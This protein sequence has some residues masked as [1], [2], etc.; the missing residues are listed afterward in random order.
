M[1]DSEEVSMAT[2]KL[3]WP[4]GHDLLHPESDLTL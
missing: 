3:T 1:E 2:L 4:D